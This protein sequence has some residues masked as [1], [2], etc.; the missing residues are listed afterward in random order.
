MKKLLKK[1]SFVAILFLTFAT[2]Q[3]QTPVVHLKFDNNL[4]NDGSGSLAFEVGGANSAGV[5][6]PYSANN[7]EGS[8]AINFTLIG[9]DTDP[10]YNLIQNG[11]GFDAQIRSTTN[12]SITGSDART[13]SAWV[14]YDDRLDTTNGSHTIVNM[15]DPAAPGGSYGRTTF[16]FAAAN[17]EIQL[18]VSGANLKHFY[19]NGEDIEDLGWHHVAYTYPSAGTLGDIVYYLDGVA[20]DDNDAGG[21]GNENIVLSTTADKIYIGTRGNNTTKWFDG[22]GIDDVRIFDVELTAAQ[23]L[24]VY[25][26][27]VLSIAG[28]AFGELKAYPNEVVDFLQIETASNNSLEINVFDITGKAIIKTSGN[29]VDMSSLNSGLYIVKVREDNKVANLKILK[30]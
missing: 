7:I 28:F 2:V 6:V 10:S 15:G 29:S 4:N 9:D 5:T 14:R 3:A 27:N 11:G 8:A 13:V 12:S 25:N 20:V 1:L 22:G 17:N 23:M 18:G 24:N 19:T 21:G 26:E 30:K 16:T